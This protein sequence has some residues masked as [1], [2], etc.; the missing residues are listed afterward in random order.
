M[1]PR[2]V[3]ST[4]LAVLGLPAIPLAAQS[5]RRPEAGA[6][7][8]GGLPVAGGEA[9]WYAR[10]LALLG[11]TAPD[12]WHDR[13]ALGDSLR[14]PVDWRILRPDM[15]AIVNTAR[16]WGRN[17]GVVWAGRGL[18][19]AIQGG[20]SARWGPLRLQLAPIA[21]R[22]QNAAF[23]LLPNGRTGALAFGDPRFPGNIDLPQRFG[24]APYQ[25]VDLGDSELSLSMFG[26]RGG[27]SSARQIWG[28]AR[29]YPL[30]MSTNAG[31]F[32]HVFGGSARPLDIGIGTV[33]GRLIAGR[34]AQSAWSPVQSGEPMR[35]TSALTGTFS[36]R[37]LPWLS[38]GGNRE[39]QGRW[40]AGGLTLDRVL[41][42]FQGVL[43]NNTGSINTNGE[44]Q[45][46]SVF[47][48]AAFA[49][50]G[51]EAYA[52]MSREDFANDLRW[53]VQKPDDL[54]SIM[55]GFAKVWSPDGER[56]RTLRAE[57]V[58][59]ELSHHE[60]LQR[61]FRT[62]IPPYT[63]TPTYQGLTSR[64]QL[65]GSPVAYGGA[66]WTIEWAERSAAGR[67][68]VALERALRLD[69]LR[70]TGWARRPEVTYA[71]RIESLRFRGRRDVTIGL[72]PMYTLNEDL[73]PG[74]DRV[75]LNAT[76]RWRGW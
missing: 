28:P 65:L 70:P 9:H 22:S 76:L 2:V 35:F 59:G 60:R 27:V 45:F 10:D 29:D 55:L 26:L 57:V 73:V 61:G 40:P 48:R 21:F 44:N 34:I 25:R 46:V 54:A 5:P 6:L 7:D 72:T 69:W 63:H 31:G 43:N 16:P 36:P 37:G 53:L 14:R 20:V 42:P 52:E 49:P 19:A 64:G 74:R 24:A 51:L 67:T 32:P 56:L 62:P 33:E 18:T 4:L 8:L 68:A 41:R 12:P 11:T 17:D 50:D 47:L 15:Q 39:V 58:N 13:R 71:V 75:G 23:R 38:F 66:G 30:V 3:R 1:I